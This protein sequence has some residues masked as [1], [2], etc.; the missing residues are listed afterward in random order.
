MLCVNK[1]F[2]KITKI[3]PISYILLWEIA[4]NDEIKFKM[5]IM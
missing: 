5:R 2:C 3:I 4:I 1:N